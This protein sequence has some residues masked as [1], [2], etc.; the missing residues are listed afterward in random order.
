MLGRAE[1]GEVEH[2]AL[3]AP[4]LDVVRRGAHLVGQVLAARH[5]LGDLEQ[6]AGREDALALEAAEVDRLDPD[7]LVDGRHAP[8]VSFARHGCPRPSGR[9]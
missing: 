6:Q 2:L 1:A 3:V 5:G 4:Q 8:I 7:Q 9:R